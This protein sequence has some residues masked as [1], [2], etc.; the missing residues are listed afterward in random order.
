MSKERK[1]TY[2][3]ASPAT[4]SMRAGINR[5]NRPL[6]LPIEASLRRRLLYIYQLDL[7]LLQKLIIIII[8]ASL[9]SRQVPCGHGVR[10]RLAP[11]RQP[12][13]VMR[14]NGQ[15]AR[16][17]YIKSV[18]RCTQMGD[19]SGID[20]HYLKPKLRLPNYYYHESQLALLL[21]RWGAWAP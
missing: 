8:I 4:R 2:C 10:G 20:R 11:E 3:I 15:R 6:W 21:N 19:S 12:H 1:S 17:P 18:L 14:D 16:N 5:I 13:S 7:T 9:C